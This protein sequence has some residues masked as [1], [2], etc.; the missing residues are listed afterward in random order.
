M[1]S[2]DDKIRVFNN[3]TGKYVDRLGL[4]SK[5]EDCGI[6]IRCVKDKVK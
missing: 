3:I 2:K 5:K 6:P 1:H 4:G